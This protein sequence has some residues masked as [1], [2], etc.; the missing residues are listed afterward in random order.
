M[1]KKINIVIFL[2]L[3]FSMAIIF[4][5]KEDKLVSYLERRYLAQADDITFEN[6]KN[7][8]L[9]TQVESYA[10]DQFPFR[11][12]LRNIKAFA[13]YNIFMKQENQN[14]IVADGS[15]YE[16][17]NSYSYDNAKNTISKINN[18]AENL[19]YDN[20]CYFALIPDK[21]C[22]LDMNGNEYNY[23]IIEDAVTDNLSTAIS[24]I[25]IYDT[26]TDK[27]Y[28]KTDLHWSQDKIIDTNNRII[29]YLDV[30][31]VTNTPN[32]VSYII[33]DYNG[34]YAARSA[35]SYIKDD[36]VYLSNERI[37]KSFVYNY[38]TSLTTPVYDLDKLTDEKSLD[39]YDIFL[40]GASPLLKVTAPDKTGETLILFRD[41]YGSSI[42]PLLL[43]YYDTIYLVDLR[44]INSSL[45][46]KFIEIKPEYD[47][48]FLY[49]TSMIEI[50]GNFKNSE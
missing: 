16:I 23:N 41:S 14:I 38:E 30:T 20:N 28:Y 25:P 7:S 43:E 50:S 13:N 24:Y 21:S 19:F 11:D 18:I 4:F 22:Y 44:Y 39:K 45:I 29:E 2:G 10:L 34:S 33:D 37:N 49:S 6:I 36:I 15:M 9:V 17:K 31:D 12:E 46:E 27:D 48:L 26:L 32:Y 3:I 1:N 5:I 35:L 47:V 42:A 8:E 40:S